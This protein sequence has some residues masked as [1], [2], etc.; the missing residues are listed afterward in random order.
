VIRAVAEGDKHTT[1]RLTFVGIT[2]PS[3]RIM[4][5]VY[6][7]ADPERPL[8][9]TDAPQFVSSF[10]FY[11]PAGEQGEEDVT[12]SLNA[13]VARLQRSGLLAVDK[14]VK[15]TAIAVPLK[16]QDDID[17]VKIPF[18]RLRLSAIRNP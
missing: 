15:I 5:R 6:L 2:P 17:E 8:P 9:G 14:P 1:L 3:T 4:V 16:P 12:L 7:N 13:A 11:G 18:K 10:S